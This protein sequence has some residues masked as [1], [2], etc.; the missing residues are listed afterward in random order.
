MRVLPLVRSEH[1]PRAR[2]RGRHAHFHRPARR[3]RWV[4]LVNERP[5]RPCPSSA[6]SRIACSN[7]PPGSTRGLDAIIE[8]GAG[9]RQLRQRRSIGEAATDARHEP[10]PE[11]RPEP[12]R[13]RE[14]EP[15]PATEPEPEPPAIAEDETAHPGEAAPAPEP[16]PEPEPAPPAPRPDA[17]GPA[18]RH[19]GEGARAG[20]RGTPGS[21]RSPDGA[22]PLRPA[23][24]A[25]RRDARTARG[26]SDQRRHGRGNGHA[27][28]RQHGRGPLWP[29]DERRRH[30]GASGNRDRAGDGTRRPSP[31]ALSEEAAGGAGGG[32]Q[33]IGQDHDDRQARQPV[34]GRRKDRGDRRRRHVPRRGRRTAADL[35]G[36]ARACPS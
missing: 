18:P 5:L 32:R 34:Q 15:A 23:P 20:R 6:S 22:Q 7:P 36:N 25:R 21:S 14:A 12:G 1:S 30:Q 26:A 2:H 27:R 35:G 16:E 24:G 28:H 11:T 29:D 10:V 33:R 3:I 4:A 8:E 31:A 19:R 13:E 9:G 17:G